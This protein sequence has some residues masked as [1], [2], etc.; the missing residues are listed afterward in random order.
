MSSL[1]FL[2]QTNQDSQ[3]KKL[4]V[5]AD[6]H[7]LICHG[8]GRHNKGNNSKKRVKGRTTREG[9]VKRATSRW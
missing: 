2:L 9:K 7:F 8:D 1:L 5:H 6:V 4:L 3:H